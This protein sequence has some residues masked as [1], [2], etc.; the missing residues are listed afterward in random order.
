MEKPEIVILGAGFGGV[1]TAL[2]LSSRLPFA[3]ITIINQSPFHCY[4]PDLYE[5]ATA[6]FDATK[7]SQEALVAAINLPLEQIFGTRKNISFLVDSVNSVDLETKSVLTG[8]KSLSYNY[9]VISLGSTTNFFGIEGTKE[10]AHPLKTT[11]DALRCRSDLEK[12]FSQTDKPTRV[13]VAGGGF[14]GVELAAEMSLL[15]HPHSE[16]V[17][18]EA[19][20]SILTGMPEWSQ[21]EALHRLEKLGVQ[22]RT[23]NMITKIDEKQIYC[24]DKEP[25]GYDYLVWT[26]GV[27]AANLNGAIKGVEFTKKGQIH[28]SACL[29]L[30]GH[31]EVYVVG[32]MAEYIDETKNTPVPPA[33]WSAISEGKVAALNIELAIKGKPLKKYSPP[34]PSFVVAVGG[35]YALTNVFGLEMTG[36][37]VWWLKQL[38]TIHYLFS[39]LPVRAV[40]SIW[41]KGL[42]VFTVHDPKRGKHV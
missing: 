3:L 36:L 14:S 40:F 16:I 4:S 12:V 23:G 2:D 11:E 18:L 27:L 6:S 10:Y 29:N 7:V 19:L 13:V 37:L 26:S 39:I 24:Q 15:P 33:A 41:W 22:V 1:R 35:K 9:L 20:P 17:L 30:A 5:V 25:L 32:D 8:T 34:Y 21:A 38:I 42:K 28:T 31:P